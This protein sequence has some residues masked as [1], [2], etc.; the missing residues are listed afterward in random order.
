MKRDTSQCTGAPARLQA[1]YDETQQCVLIRL[2]DNGKGF[3][4]AMASAQT[5]HGLANMQQRCK[6]LGATLEF[7]SSEDGTVLSL[8]L[9]IIRKA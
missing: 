4:V 7:D 2:S 9:P 5:G 3:D 6:L 8:S 1:E